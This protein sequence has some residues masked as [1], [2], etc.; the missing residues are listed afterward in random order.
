MNNSNNNEEEEEEV[1][2]NTEIDLLIDKFVASYS[3]GP[4]FESP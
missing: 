4:R 2:L 1:M 3:V